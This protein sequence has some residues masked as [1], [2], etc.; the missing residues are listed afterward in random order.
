MSPPQGKDF[1]VTLTIL[2]SPR[3]QG[4][5]FTDTGYITLTR[6]SGKCCVWEGRGLG[7]NSFQNFYVD[8]N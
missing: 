8:V 5:D 3:A 7:K 1:L 2:T 6:R 4:R